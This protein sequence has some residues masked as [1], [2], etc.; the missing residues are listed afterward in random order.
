MFLCYFGGPIAL[1]VASVFSVIHFHWW[2]IVVIPI[3]ALFWFV[4]FSKSSTGAA[5]GRLITV[6]LAI[7]IA[8]HIFNPFGW[9]STLFFLFAALAFWFGRM[10]YIAATFFLRAFV[11]RNYRAYNLLADAIVVRRA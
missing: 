7:A 11:I 6:A 4:Y 2:S 3:L 1:I 8:V 9:N 10:L 5:S